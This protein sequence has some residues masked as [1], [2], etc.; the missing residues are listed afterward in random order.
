ME[1]VRI[2]VVGVGT[3]GSNHARVLASAPEAD[4]V[5]FYDTDPSRTAAAA[6][7]W[8][9]RAFDG[10]ESLLGEVEAITVAAPTTAHHEITLRALD[11]GVHALV[12]KP[13]ASSLREAKE[14]DEAA[15]S[16]GSVLAVGHLERFNPAVEALLATENDPRFVEIHR[17]SP[18]DVRGLDVSVILDLMIHDIDILIQLVRSPLEHLDAVGVPVLSTSIDIANARL[19]FENGCVANL[20][21][22]RISLSKQRKIRIFERD[23]YTSLDYTD[24]AVTVYRRVGELPP[25]RDLTPQAFHRFIQ[26]ET[27]PVDRGEPL[28]RELLH[29]LHAVR[30][31]RA[32]LV[33]PAEATEALRV[34]HQ[35]LER[36]KADHGTDG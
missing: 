10:L 14:M 15:Q 26:R 3:W 35:I 1:P 21:A 24:Q 6:D 8:G 22:S 16:S 4:L 34:G 20:T 2:A 30:R 31:R 12:E 5:G 36:I 25:P 32:K 11:R 9:G 13:I 33:T 18:F 29:F 17:M 7:R 19:R 23:R 28:Q 27:V